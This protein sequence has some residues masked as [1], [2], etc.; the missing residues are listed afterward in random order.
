MYVRK[1][2]R[3]K[4]EKKKLNFTPLIIDRTFQDQNFLNPFLN[5]L[6]LTYTHVKKSL[7]KEIHDD[8]S[9]LNDNAPRRF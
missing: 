2:K 5:R 6:H 8:E 1:I 9:E 3:K 7:S 4:K